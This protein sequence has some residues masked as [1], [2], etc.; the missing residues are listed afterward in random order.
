MK[1]PLKENGGL[2]ASILWTLAIV[3]GV[4]VANIYYIQPLLNMIRHEL[5]ISEFRT[6]LI[7][8]VTQIGY[9]AGLLF[10]TPLGD[11]YQRKKIILVTI[12]VL[13]TVYIAFHNSA[14]RVNTQ[15]DHAFK[16]AITEDYNERLAY[17]SYYHPEPTN[18][19]IKMYT[20]AP[21]LHQKVKSYTIRTRQGKTIYTFK[22][23]L[24]EQT[25]KRMLNQYILSQLKPIKPDELNATFR[26][27][28]SDHGITGR[29]GTI[30]YNKSISQHS[31]QSSAIPRTAYNT[32]RYIVD[33]TQ[34]IKVQVWVNYDF[35]TILRHIDNTLFWLI[36]QLMILIFILIFLKKEKDTQ[37]LLTRMNIDMEK[38]E[39]YIGNKKCNIQKL[40]LTLLNMLYERAG[41][42]VSREEIK[43]SFWPT[44][45]N[46]NEKIDAHIKSIRKVLKEFQEYKLITVRGKGYY[47]R[48]P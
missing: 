24:D 9:A 37:T 10:I 13:Y 28:L 6:N 31:D 26:K 33:I 32:P 14:E 39:L 44:D 20:I 21:S 25:A 18:W 42:C 27:I 3:A 15:I 47:L 29:T 17:I 34:N 23:S 38:Q 43:K 35:K 12:T 46:A 41:T 48:I 45:D 16:S 30:Y 4:S 40:D 7:A 8:M 11:L 5:G 22:D 19:D 36:G 1:Q 2:P